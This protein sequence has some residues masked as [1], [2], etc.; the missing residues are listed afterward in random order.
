MYNRIKSILASLPRPG[1]IQRVDE[2]ERHGSCSTTAG[3]VGGELEAGR[4]VLRGLEGG[5]DSV[6]EGEVERLG[7]EVPEHVGEVSW[8]TV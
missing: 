6:L 5:L 3:N 8:K 2:E 1:V 7:R 4:S